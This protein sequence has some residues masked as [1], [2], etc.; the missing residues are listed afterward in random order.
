MLEKSGKPVEKTNEPTHIVGIGASAG[1][2]IALEEFFKKVPLKT[3]LSFVV[4]QHLPADHKSMMVELLSRHTELP[5]FYIEENMTVEPNSVYLIP[6][7]K[8]VKLFHNQFLL[9]NPDD[10]QRQLNLPIDIFF[11]SLADD[12]EKKSI[13]VI[14]SGTG[15]DSSTVASFCSLNTTSVLDDLTSS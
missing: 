2:L 1:G 5:V 6:P 14:L 9:S 12:Q 7:G 3:G 15:S 11:E 8:N 13:A 10:S 4:I